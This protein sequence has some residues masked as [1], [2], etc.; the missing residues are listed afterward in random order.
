VALRGY[1]PG[2]REHTGVRR[3]GC[4]ASDDYL[5]AV[6][7]LRP[8]PEIA[9][10]L[11]RDDAG[12]AAEIGEH[13]LGHVEGDGENDP[14]GARLLEASDASRRRTAVFSPMPFTE[15]TRPASQAAR[16]SGMV[17]MP[18]AS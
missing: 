8:T 5:H 15:R 18:S 11:G 3:V 7:R 4:G 6:H 14:R 9:G 2:Q 17:S 16:R 10:H 1:D 13:L 12:R